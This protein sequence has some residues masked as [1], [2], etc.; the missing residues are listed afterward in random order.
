MREF[1]NQADTLIHNIKSN[2]LEDS[3]WKN[4]FSVYFKIF[5]FLSAYINMNI[6]DPYNSLSL[7]KEVKQ[8]QNSN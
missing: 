8:N 3:F 5:Y 2:K 7:Y 1:G 6:T 4:D